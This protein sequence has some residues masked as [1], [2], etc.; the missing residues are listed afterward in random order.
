MELIKG[1]PV[2]LFVRTCTGRDP[3]GAP[4]YAETAVTVDNVLVQPVSGTD[5]PTRNGLLSKRQRVRLCI[6]K[7]DPHQWEDCRVEFF[8]ASWRVVG[9][10]EQYLDALVPLAWNKQV[11]VERLG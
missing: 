10:A 11:E 4:E 3:F 9:F 2:T 1:I 7:G 6:P 8:G 5:T